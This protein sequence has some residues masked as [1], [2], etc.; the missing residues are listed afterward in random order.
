MSRRTVFSSV[1]GKAALLKLAWDWTLAGDDEPVAMVDRPAV[2]RML[3]E[4]DPRRLVSLWCT[5]AVHVTSRAAQL[6]RALR[7]AAGI[8][9]EAAELLHLVESE[10]LAGARAFVGQIERLGGLRAGL[11]VAQ[12]ADLVWAHMDAS[13]YEPQ[14]VKRGWTLAAYQSVLERAIAAVILVEA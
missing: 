8:D 1:G 14:V 6:G 11:S 10:S 12:A 13:L 2:Q 9:P 7:L 5:N 4:T 3:T